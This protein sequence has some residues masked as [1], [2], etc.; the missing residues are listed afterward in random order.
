MLMST[1]YNPTHISD[2]R[3]SYVVLDTNVLNA[4][5][6]DE[7]FLKQFTSIFN[8]VYIHIDPIVELEF[9]RGSYK[10]DTYKEKRAILNMSF[11]YPMMDHQEIYKKVKEYALII[12]RIYSYHNMSQVPLGDLLITARLA[13]HDRFLFITN[14]KEDFN[15]LLFDCKAVVS[16]ERAVRSKNYKK[17]VLDHLHILKFSKEKY[18]RLSNSFA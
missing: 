3:G 10:Q 12:G 15:S 1:F 18:N 8:S 17:T 11:F 2:L 14:D 4:L 5:A 7:G 13:H 9:L 16:I 6:S